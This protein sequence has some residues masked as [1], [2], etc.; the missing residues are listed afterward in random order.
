MKRLI[1]GSIR[2]VSTILGSAVVTVVALL[3]A[4]G[5]MLKPGPDEWSMPLR[6]GTAEFGVHLDVEVAS[7]LRVSTHPVGLMLLDG[8]SLSTRY[9][10]LRFTRLDEEHLAIDCRVC[11]L[12][13]PA[14]GSEALGLDAVRVTITQRADVLRGTV[15]AGGIEGRYTGRFDVHGMKLD[16]RLDRA[17]IA[18]YYKVFGGNVPEASFADIAGMASLAVKFELP[19]AKVRVEP[20]IEGFAVSGL[21]TERLAGRLPAVACP[22]QSESRRAN[23]G[24]WLPRAVVAAED[25]RYYEHPGY[26]LDELLATIDRNQSSSRI[27]RGASTIPQQLSKLL[28]V[29]SERTVSRKLRELLYATEMEQT[30]GKVRMLQLYLAVVPWGEGTCGAEAAARHNFNVPPAKLSGAQAVWLA[31]MLHAPDREAARWTS[32]GGIDLVRATWVAKGLQ[33]VKPVAREHVLDEFATMA[34]G[35]KPV[36]IVALRD[37]P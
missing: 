24:F 2:G 35:M 20:T 37:L 10:E 31:A 11:R 12:Q 13:L 25:Q 32:S 34:P 8:R 7:L 29:G 22:G 6:I 1:I 3:C 30:L 33:R 16:L 18:A 15:S 26:D 17:A 14:F 28:Q 23:F 4:A 21:G 9:G 27:E 5:W 19:S 36:G